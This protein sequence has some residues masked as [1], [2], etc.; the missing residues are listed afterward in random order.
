MLLQETVILYV[1]AALHVVM[2]IVHKD[3]TF[4]VAV[5]MLTVQDYQ[6]YVQKVDI[7]EYP[8]V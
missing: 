5:H 2:V 6:D 7:L 4:A 3:I 1:Q 8:A